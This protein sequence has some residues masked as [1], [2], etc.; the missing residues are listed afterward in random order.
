MNFINLSGNI[1]AWSKV[2]KIITVVKFL[3]IKGSET[4]TFKDYINAVIVLINCSV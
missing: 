2:V 1:E 3:H 4:E